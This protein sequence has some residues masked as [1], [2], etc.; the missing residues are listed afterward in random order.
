MKIIAFCGKSGCGKSTIIDLLQNQY[1]NMFTVKSYTTRAV[2]EYDKNDIF[3]HKFVSKEFYEQHKDRAISVYHA[4]QGYVSWT[5]ETSFDN[6]KINLYAI[7]V[8]EAVK[9]LYPYCKKNNHELLIIY[10][11]VSEEIRKERYLKRESTLNGYKTEEHLDKTP[12][13]DFNGSYAIIKTD[14]LSPEMVA[15]NILS[16]II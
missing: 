4:P 11:D 2:R 14:D 8:A 5:D 6:N 1:D 13:N 10:L 16:K 3:T 7:D 15:K 12:L 9:T